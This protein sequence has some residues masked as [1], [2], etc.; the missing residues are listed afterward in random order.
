MPKGM[1][2]AVGLFLAGTMAHG[3]FVQEPPVPKPSPA[4][5]APASKAQKSEVELQAELSLVLRSSARAPKWT[6]LWDITRLH[7]SSR[8]C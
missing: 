1:K 8:G 7:A 6:V 4:T 5:E 3:A 2:F